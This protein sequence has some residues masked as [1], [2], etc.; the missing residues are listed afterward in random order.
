VLVEVT[1]RSAISASSGVAG[2]ETL[3]VLSVEADDALAVALE[4][5]K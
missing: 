3:A 4:V 2:T 1:P 5:G